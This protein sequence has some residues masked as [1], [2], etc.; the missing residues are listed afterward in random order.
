MKHKLFT[1]EQHKAMDFGNMTMA[2][3]MMRY[4]RHKADMYEQAW[5]TGRCKECDTP[6]NND[7]KKI[8]FDCEVLNK[9]K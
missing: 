6:L 8:C 2:S 5:K 4:W 3:D 1:K 9:A 7:E